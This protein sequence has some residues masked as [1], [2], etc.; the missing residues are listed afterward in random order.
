M[1]AVRTCVIVIGLSGVQFKELSDD[2]F[3]IGRARTKKKWKKLK[4]A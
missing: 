2:L 4:I 3:E 1:I